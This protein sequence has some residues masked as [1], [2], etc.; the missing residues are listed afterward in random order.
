MN[1]KSNT[2]HHANKRETLKR[3]VDAAK[4]E[5]A[6]KGLADGRID[7]I[8]QA[9]GVTKQL[10]YHYFRSKEELFACVLEESSAQTMQDLVALDV[11]PLPPREALRML[12]S[13]M[14]RPYRDPLLSSL[15]QEGIRYHAYHATPSNSFID[16]APALNLKMRR[17]LERGVQ[18]GDFRADVDADLLL[19]AAVLATT[20]AFVSR[21]TV[22][23]LSG[24]DL[25]DERDAD[26]WHRFSIEFVLSAIERER[27]TLHPLT[28]PIEPVM[29]PESASHVLP[30]FAPADR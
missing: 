19:A 22:S 6:A 11:D 10:V 29:H 27:S 14:I 20:S 1:D 24:V 7:L 28:R 30:R 2:G 13:R 3:I 26:A 18:S 21:Y 15:A 16:M 17:V 25:A 4:H 12:L 23:N 8:A 9:A 5:F